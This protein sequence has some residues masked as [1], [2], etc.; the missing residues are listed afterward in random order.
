MNKLA[1]MQ[2]FVAIVD[3]GSMTGAATLLGKALPTVV[4]S[5][6]TLEQALGVRLLR[7]TTRR[8]SLTEEGRLY[9]ER[10]RRILADV[11]EAEQALT[12]QQAEPRGELRVTAPVLFGRLWVTPAVTGFLRAHEQVSVDLVLLDR[13]VNLVEEGFD[14]G[15]RIATLTDSSMIATRVGEV[16]RVVV[17]SPTLLR[18]EGTPRHPRDLDARSVIDFQGGSSGSWTFQ[19]GDRSFAVPVRGRLRCNEG[20]AALQACT[21]GFGFGRFLSYQVEALVAAKRLRIV[22]R[23]F[24]P[25]PIPIH[26]IYAHARLMSPRVRVFVDWLKAHLGPTRVQ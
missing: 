7:R 19:E 1:A 16:R 3:A 18:R 8:M 11:D 22:L 25:P 13:V 2:T 26:V 20:A 5:L 4:R 6:A 14:V 23:R 9:V 12:Q 17:A 24:E 10:C 15:V 21:E